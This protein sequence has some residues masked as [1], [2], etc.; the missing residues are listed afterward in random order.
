MEAWKAGGRLSLPFHVTR[1]AEFQKYFLFFPF[2]PSNKLSEVS[3]ALYLYSSIHS[4]IPIDGCVTME[5]RIEAHP[6]SHDPY[7][8]PVS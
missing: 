8:L 5:K 1:S 4:F 2:S 3:N 6:P 7:L